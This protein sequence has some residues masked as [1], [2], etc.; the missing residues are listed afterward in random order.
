MADL[1]KP[2]WTEHTNDNYFS[3]KAP[4]YKKIVESTFVEGAVKKLN[5]RPADTARQSPR[6]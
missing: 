1:P 5:G 4:L 3:G 2:E 6:Q